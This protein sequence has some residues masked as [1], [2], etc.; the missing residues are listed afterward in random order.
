MENNVNLSIDDSKYKIK[1]NKRKKSHNTEKRFHQNEILKSNDNFPTRNLITKKI[2]NNN[3]NNNLSKSLPNTKILYEE[4]PHSMSTSH[5]KSKYRKI[6]ISNKII[7]YENRPINKQTYENYLNYERRKLI[8]EENKSKK[9]SQCKSENHYPLSYRKNNTMEDKHNPIQKLIYSPQQ[10]NTNIRYF[11]ISPNNQSTESDYENKNNNIIYLYGNDIDT[12]SEKKNLNNFQNVA[13][14]NITFNNLGSNFYQPINE[15]INNNSN[16][17]YNHNEN[18]PFDKINFPNNNYINYSQNNPYLSNSLNRENGYEKQDL[19]QIFKR[20]NINNNIYKNFKHNTIKNN[21]FINIDNN[22]IFSF[23]NI[24]N[25]KKDKELINIYKG[26]LIKIFIKFMM[27]F[28]F[29]QSKKYFKYFISQ[30]KKYNN[31]IT[32]PNK[33]YI[34]KKFNNKKENKE[35]EDNIKSN[36]LNYTKNKNIKIKNNNFENYEPDT[37]KSFTSKKKFSSMNL[38]KNMT[39]NRYLH[40]EKDNS[41]KYLF[42]RKILRDN[43]DNEN[44]NKKEKKLKKSCSNLYIPVKNRNCSINYNNYILCSKPKYHIFNELKIDKTAKYKDLNSEDKN[45]NNIFLNDSNSINFYKN[46][47]FN[48]MVLEKQNPNFNLSMSK[49]SNKNNN[50]IKNNKEVS[51][52]SQIQT[53]LYKRILSKNKNSDINIYRKKTE[54]L[55]WNKNKNE[56]IKNNEYK[57]S[58]LIKNNYNFSKKNNIKINEIYFNNN[59]NNRNNINISNDISNYYLYDKPINMVSLKNNNPNIDNENLNNSVRGNIIMTLKN[60]VNKNK[61][62]KRNPIKFNIDIKKVIQV[63]TDDKR[64]FINFSYAN[65]GNKYYINQNNKIYKKNKI[66]F[67]KV[68]S[69]FIPGRYKNNNNKINNVNQNYSF[70]DASDI[71]NP[72]LDKYIVKKEFKN[73][74][75]K[76][77]NIIN[78]IIFEKKYIFFI[79]LKRIKFC[80]FLYKIID[81]F[82]KRLIKKFFDNYKNH[83]NIKHNITNNRNKIN[84]SFKE[85]ITFNNNLDDLNEIYNLDDFKNKKNK[86]NFLIEPRINSESNYINP[87]KINKLKGKEKLK[88]LIK[89]TYKN[90]KQRNNTEESDTE[91]DNKIITSIEDEKKIETNFHIPLKKSKQFKYFNSYIPLKKKKIFYSKIDN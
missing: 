40:N 15:Q 86:Y 22:D 47:L 81:N 57:T 75:L 24:K 48:S 8:E 88:F 69:L 77:N 87:K 59:L 39:K 56:K 67:S 63:K 91:E 66:I 80:K 13:F 21:Q 32:S 68:N 5:K 50:I 27:D 1:V 43:N 83:N 12:L 2:K 23:E 74:I 25:D 3:K 31:N 64:L 61:L 16:Y 26:K 11:M 70:K 17:Y 29:K 6:N 19:T 4:I 78:K 46:N 9:L 60:I 52:N 42:V 10:R 53:R 41:E 85:I 36:N 35:N 90:R 14:S 45:L 72:N 7:N 51:N 89:Q 82:Y 34:K 65:I 84:V 55:N 71:I 28:N 20:N 49:Q 73:E 37:V 18:I 62:F 79:C 58:K 38:M 76:L 33:R 30:L 44:D 54:K